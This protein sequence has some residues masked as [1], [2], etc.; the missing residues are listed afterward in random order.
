MPG[1]ERLSRFAERPSQ[2][3][4]QSAGAQQQQQQFPGEG[5]EGGEGG[6]TIITATSPPR[7]PQVPP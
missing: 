3:V 5:K 1:V 2:D 7:S 4:T 6:A